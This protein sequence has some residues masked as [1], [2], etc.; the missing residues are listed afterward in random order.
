MVAATKKGII[1]KT[2]LMAYSRPRKGGIKA[3]ILAKD[4]SLVNVRLT[5][6]ERQLMLA[7]KNGKAIKFHERDAR[8]IGRSS[9]GVRG[10]MLIAKNELKRN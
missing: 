6:G 10:I 1:K 3:I 5:N 4:D 9:K 8:S 2:D 7:T